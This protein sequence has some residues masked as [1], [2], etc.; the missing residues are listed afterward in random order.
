MPY[1]PFPIYSVKY[2][3]KGMTIATEAT[4]KL[5]TKVE[6]NAFAGATLG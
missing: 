2:G 6:N 1:Y 5:L 3:R 4:L